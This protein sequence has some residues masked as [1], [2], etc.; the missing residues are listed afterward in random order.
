MNTLI[1]PLSGEWDIHNPPG[2]HPNAT[3]FIAKKDGR[4]FAHSILRWVLGGVSASDWYG[5]GRPVHSP[6]DGFVVQAHDGEPERPVTSLVR[7]LL[8][9]LRLRKKEFSKGDLS[10]F[11]GNYVILK[12]GDA[13]VLMAHLKCGTVKPV[14]GTRI[15][16]GDPIGEVGNSGASLAPHLHLQVMDGVDFFTSAILPFTI[17]GAEAFID[18]AWK[19]AGEVVPKKGL[20]LRGG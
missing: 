10:P 2:H 11:A 18:G 6:C 7:D 14:S 4:P 15:N 3:D 16:A 9:V 8:R 19:K 20:K 12:L 5:Y 17:T 1:F 13:Y